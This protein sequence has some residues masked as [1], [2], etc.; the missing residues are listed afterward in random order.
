MTPSN[1]IWLMDHAAQGRF[2]LT[3]RDRL[4]LLHRMSTQDLNSLKQGQGRATILLTALARI[5]D[6][7]VVYHRGESALAVC[8]EGMIRTVRLWLQKHIFFNDQIKTRDISAE[9]IHFGLYGTGAEAAIEQ[10]APGADQLPLHHFIEKEDA[11]GLIFVARRF[12]IAGAG[13]T[14]IAPLTLADSLRERFTAQLGATPLS[15]TDYDRLRI[16]SGLPVA[17]RELT[18]DY[19]P[20]E[21]G[22]WDAVSFQKGCYIGQEIIARMESRNKLA[23]TLV[24][25]GAAQPIPA[26]TALIQAGREV[27]KLTSTAETSTGMIGLGYVKTDSVAGQFQTTEGL[28]VELITV[29]QPERTLL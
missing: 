24:K 22:L 11:A 9:T 4:D 25:L 23:R 28:A 20:L 8:G 15:A 19:I 16:E 1:P 17:G 10:F 12:P 2:E 26:G 7:M 13:F 21:S 5:I 27:G 6:Q 18:E 29:L 14:V 3:G